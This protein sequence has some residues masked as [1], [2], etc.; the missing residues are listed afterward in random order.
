MFHDRPSTLVISLFVKEAPV[1][2]QNGREL[3]GRRLETQRQDYVI[4][5]PGKKVAQHYKIAKENMQTTVRV[6]RMM[7]GEAGNSTPGLAD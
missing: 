2:Y 1:P 5:G 7:K 4:S 3:S 6:G